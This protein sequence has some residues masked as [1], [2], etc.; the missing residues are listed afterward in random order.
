MEQLSNHLQKKNGVKMQKHKDYVKDLSFYLDQDIKTGVVRTMDS[1]VRRLK[2]RKLLLILVILSTLINGCADE[3][4]QNQE[5]LSELQVTAC[6]SA[7]AGG[8]CDTRL[9]DLEIVTKE[10]CC[11]VLGKCC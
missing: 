8:T 2:M 10:K 6:N 1:V 4:V 5:Q 11:S 9:A 3:E 7:D